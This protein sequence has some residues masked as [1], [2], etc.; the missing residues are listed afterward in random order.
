MFKEYNQKQIQLLP[1]DLESSIARDH[2][3][4][5]IS[6]AV[7]DMDIAFIENT[8]S[9]DGQ[10]A[11]NPGMLLKILVYGY[12][13]GIRGSRKLADR[14]KEDIIFMWLSGRNTPDFRTISDFRKEKLDNFEN[15]FEQVLN[16]CFAI[17][18]TRVGKV[19]LD[20]SKVLANASKN[21]AVYR[22]NLQKRRELI[23]NKVKEIMREAELADEEEERLYGNATPHRTGINFD[24]PEIS[25]KIGKAM[26]KINQQRVRLEKKKAILMAK[27]SDVKRKERL[28][29]KDRN[30]FASTDKDAT[31][32]MMKEGYVAPGYNIQLATEHQVIL[33]YG[34][35]SNRNDQ[36]LL[37]PMIEEIK[38]RTKRK[39]EAIITD[40]GYG[41]KTN[42]RYLKHNKIQGYAPYNT[43]EQER[44]LRNKGLYQYPKNPD[45][46]LERYKFLQRLR[47]SSEEGKAMMTRRRE[48]VEPVFGNIKRNMEFRRFGLRGKAKCKVEL[49]LISVAHNLKKIK[50]WVK[51]LSEW[52][53]GQQKGI[54]LGLVLGYRTS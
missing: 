36:K 7:D 4:R 24:D 16:I 30:S 48:D 12:A 29:R 34:L 2:L 37:K 32:M 53:D 18:L 39:P 49:G 13:I 38:S 43:Y 6:K 25:A 26:K 33:A 14:L 22:I 31:V 3:A 50:S 44:I 19:S 47:L 11:Y 27:E 52:D 21:K 54:E 45:V 8:Y 1:Q 40:M 5:L 17:G 20:G 23:H 42:Y 15:V 9:N 41:S 10:R 46:E 28:M 35:S 51:K